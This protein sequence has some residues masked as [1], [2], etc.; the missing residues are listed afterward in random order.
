METRYFPKRE[1]IYGR[2]RSRCEGL[3]PREALASGRGGA[4]QPAAP[5]LVG[6]PQTA[7]TP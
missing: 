1:W 6:A 3:R 4:L 2:Q 5:E 7:A